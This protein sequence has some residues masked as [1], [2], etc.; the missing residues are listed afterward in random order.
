MIVLI[1]RPTTNEK[2]QALAL[3][4]AE[5]WNAWELYEVLYSPK[6]GETLGTV[7]EDH[8]RFICAGNGAT[9][10]SAALDRLV[11]WSAPEGETTPLRALVERM[12][13]LMRVV[14]VQFP[15]PKG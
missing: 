8:A 13:A 6:E 9:L 2:H 4:E 10:M 11:V 3:V 1:D 7:G 5:T 15:G 14:E 12:T